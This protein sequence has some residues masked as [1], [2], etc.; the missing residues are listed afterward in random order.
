VR[1]RQGDI[2]WVDFGE[3]SG[4]EPGYRHPG[5]VIQ[6]DTFNKSVIATVVVCEV[7]ETLKLGKARGN[8][9]LVPGEAN[10]PMQS[11]VNVSQIFTV[12]KTDLGD[13]I[14]RLDVYR[15]REV[16]DGLHFLLEG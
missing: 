6:S 2:Y 15:M 10:L 11:V 9:E 3:P 12:D 8:V 1:I 7:T 14:G 4:S 13:W 5:L 16:L